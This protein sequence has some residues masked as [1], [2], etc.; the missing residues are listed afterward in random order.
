[1]LQGIHYWCA[2]P[3]LLKAECFNKGMFVNK[4]TKKKLLKIKKEEPKTLSAK[5]FDSVMKTILSAPP[6]ENKKKKLVK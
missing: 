5:E 4:K 3:H 2:N 6:I 1:M